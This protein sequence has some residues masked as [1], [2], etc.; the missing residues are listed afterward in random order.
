MK[1]NIVICCEAMLKA[2]AN[3]D[4]V[5]TWNWHGVGPIASELSIGVSI[6]ERSGNAIKRC[7]WCGKPLPFPYEEDEKTRFLE[8]AKAQVKHEEEKSAS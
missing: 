1:K 4:V 5:P 3:R 7:P 8:E 2:I 6:R